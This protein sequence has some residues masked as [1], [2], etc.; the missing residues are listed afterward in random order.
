MLK[1]KA[2]WYGRTLV[3]I[4][5]FYPSTKKCS[6]CGEVNPMVTLDMRSWQCPVCKTIHER[7]RNAAENI[8]KEG[9]RIL[10]A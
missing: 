4:D 3:T 1:Y 7:D 9:L 6:H 8:L 10:A 5:K 2:N